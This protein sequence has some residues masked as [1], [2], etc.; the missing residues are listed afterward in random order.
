[1]EGRDRMKVAIVGCGNV[2]H[3]HIRAW[4]EASEAE[5]S[6]LVDVEPGLARSTREEMGLDETIPVLERY[7][8][9]LQ[10]ADIDIVD[11]C[12]PSYLH[13]E[14]IIAAL[15][16]GKHIVVEKPTGY[17]LE[18]CRK[19]KFYRLKYPGPKVAVAYSLRYYPVNMGVKRLIDEG[20]I[21]E[22]ISAQLTWNHPFDPE[23]SAE[24]GERVEGR[25]ADKGGRYIPGSEACGP[26]HV[27]DLACY[28]LGEVEEVFA[29]RKPSG[30]YGLAVFE[31]RSVCTMR[32]GMSS[33]WGLRN[34]T[35]LIVQ[36][37]K[38]TIHTAMNSKGEYTGTI[39]DRDGQT[40]IDASK[41]AGHG[42]RTRTEN[43][44]SAIEKDEPLIC[45][46]ED[47]IRTSELLHALWDSYNL[48]I[49]VPVHRSGKTG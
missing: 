39:A 40:P 34:P 13:A 4:Q 46:L 5:I 43:I 38:G 23:K 31:N 26:T 35:P 8:D 24:S 10:S 16:A 15:A 41:E 47:G 21:G 22:P 30:V 25:L 7:E 48:G 28:M 11:I 9:A 45:S 14:Q 36:G 33:S 18:E 19:L 6:L 37:T 29:Y 3:G 17:N 42:D 12:T 32:A 49:R 2:A 44:I 27:F 1:M 20:R